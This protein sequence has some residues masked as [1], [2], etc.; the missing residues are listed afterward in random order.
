MG[1]EQVLEARDYILSQTSVRPEIGV[2]CGSGL[3][4]LAERLDTEPTRCVISYGDIPHFPAVSGV[5]CT[6]FAE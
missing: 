5:Y 3:G 2:I 6:T 4:G 1:Y